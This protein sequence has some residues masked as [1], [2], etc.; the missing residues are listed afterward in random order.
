MEDSKE[1]MEAGE[2][3]EGAKKDE[4]DLR[5]KKLSKQQGPIV[6]LVVAEITQLTVFAQV[7]FRTFEHHANTEQ[8]VCRFLLLLHI[9]LSHTI[10]LYTNRTYNSER[11]NKTN[12]SSIQ[13]YP[14][15]K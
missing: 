6:S 5:G 9:E 4:R 10:Q 7:K 2:M 3:R 11:K 13:C 1:G 15:I 12:K 8:D 14:I